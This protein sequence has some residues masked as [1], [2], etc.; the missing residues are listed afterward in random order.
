[1]FPS[2]KKVTPPAKGVIG[3][4]PWNGGPEPA[5]VD[6]QR[7]FSRAVTRGLTREQLPRQVK[8]SPTRA[9][10]SGSSQTSSPPWSRARGRH[11]LLPAAFPGQE[12]PNPH[13]FPNPHSAPPQGR[14]A[15]AREGPAAARR[16][17][18]LIQGDP[19]AQGCCQGTALPPALNKVRPGHCSQ[20][21]DGPKGKEVSRAAWKALGK[22]EAELSQKNRPFLQHNPVKAQNL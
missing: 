9:G 17:H 20:I 16:S 4:N 1:M 14:A 22:P 8:P 19:R 11:Q 15:D 2:P 12:P 10:H 21:P 18:S 5:G 7:S 13:I 3:E 6:G